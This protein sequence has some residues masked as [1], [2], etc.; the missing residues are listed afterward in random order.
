MNTR[1]RV[2]C[3]VAA[4][5]GTGHLPAVAAETGAAASTTTARI[6]W[7]SRIVGAW[8]MTVNWVDCTTGAALRPPF[9]AL[10]TFFLDGNLIEYGSGLG[11]A[12]RS[13][14]QGTWERIGRRS[15][16]G[17]SEIQLF[18]ANGLYY[19][20]QVIERRFDVSA[21]SKTLISRASFVR[22]GIDGSILF[23]GCANETGERQPSPTGP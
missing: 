12:F 23:S 19:G 10:N 18:D 7:P 14:S 1:I 9:L 11:P 8:K 20:I 22:T 3:A 4:I 2:L 17:R 15:F 16:I 21:D 5:L 13:L 6:E